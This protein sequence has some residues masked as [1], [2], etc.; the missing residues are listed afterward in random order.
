MALYDYKC[1]SCQTVTERR[2]P[3]RD[4][5]SQIECPSCGKPAKKAISMFAV[6]GIGDGGFGDADFGDGGGMGGM[7]D[8]GGMPGMGGHGHDHGGMDDFGGMDDL[9]F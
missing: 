1:E 9:D 4:V 7:P 5:I 2:M 8:M 6:V 3:M